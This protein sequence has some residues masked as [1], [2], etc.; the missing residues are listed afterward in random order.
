MSKKWSVILILSTLMLSGCWDRI[1]LNDISIVTGIAMDPGKEKKYKL[2]I[3]VVNAPAFSHQAGGEGT[4][5][6]TFSLEG[7]SMTE[8]AH[9]M[10][11]GVTRRLVFSHTRVLFISEEIARKGIISFLEFLERSGEFRNDF[12]MLI[13]RN[14]PAS[15]F[16]R[17]T[18]PLQKIPSQKVHKQSQTFFNEWGGDPN[19]RLTD[20][21]SAVTSQGRSP[22]TGSVIISG[23]AEKGGSTENN[24]HLSPQ[25]LVEKNGAAVFDNEV[26][27][28]FLS[29]EDTRNY[30]WTQDLEQTS[31]SVPCKD[32]EKREGQSFNG[33][34]IIHTYSNIEASYKGSTPTLKVKINAD[35]ELIGTHCAKD[36]TKIETYQEYEKDT[37]EFIKEGIVGT[38]QKVQKEYGVDIY[39]FG[40]ALYRKNPK[41]FKQVKDYWNE[42]FSKAEIETDVSIHLRRSGIRNKS[43]FTDMSDS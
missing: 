28:G 41:K 42:E 38:I 24:N 3:E 39:G 8:L 30:L 11:V 12:S 19:V 35:A 22:V 15:D 25:A 29:L 32:S 2:T 36:L 4:P 14:N 34:R 27:K 1:E 13:T 18:Y 21:I 33:V 43:F 31:L 5:V 40:E 37:E 20:F 9:K 26:L 17:V 6:I 16:L 7:D 23:D 10:N